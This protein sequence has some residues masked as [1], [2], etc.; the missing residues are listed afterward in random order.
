MKKISFL[1]PKILGILFAVSFITSC[2][3]VPVFEITV[4]DLMEIRPAKGKTPQDLDK[5]KMSAQYDRKIQWRYDDGTLPRVWRTMNETNTFKIGTDYEASFTLTAKDGC[6]FKTPKIDWWD[7]SPIIKGDEKIIY[8]TMSL[9]L[10]ND[11]TIFLTNL[12]GYIAV[13]PYDF[14]NTVIDRPPQ[15]SGTINWFDNGTDAPHSWYFVEGTAYKA[16]VTLTAKPGFTFLGIAPPGEKDC[17]SC[18]EASSVDY[19][20]PGENDDGT[21]LKIT[22]VFGGSGGGAGVIN[23]PVFT[24]NDSANP[25]AQGFWEFTSGGLLS[26]QLP[27]EANDTYDKITVYFT[28]KDLDLADKG[29]QN[30]K[31]IMKPSSTGSGDWGGISGENAYVNVADGDGTWTR[32]LPLANFNWLNIQDNT[33][34][35]VSFKIKFTKIE[36]E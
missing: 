9:T 1:I 30:G 23:N 7:P 19:I 3:E 4:I 10:L 22:I 14:P 18:D 6:V 28:I 11:P 12:T 34:A 2:P 5:I 29:A 15:Y 26:W 21:T 16:V 17:F 36:F 27:A 8:V 13:P 20:P 33:E 31:L 35:D 24:R 32:T 25:D